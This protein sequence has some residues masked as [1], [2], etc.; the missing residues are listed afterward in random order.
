MIKSK[1]T[2]FYVVIY[3]KDTVFGICSDAVNTM[4]AKS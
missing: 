2:I 4:Y 1:R 3:K